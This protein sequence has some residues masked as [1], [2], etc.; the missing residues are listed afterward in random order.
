M[1]IANS[2]AWCNACRAGIS[3]YYA[4]ELSFYA[5]STVMLAFWEERRRDYPVMMLHHVVS[6]FLIGAS[7][8]QGWG[9]WPV[10]AF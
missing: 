5:A 1:P 7:Y 6:V 3:T 8:V 2:D 10:A 4:L 9:P